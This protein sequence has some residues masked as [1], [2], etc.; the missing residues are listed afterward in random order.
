MRKKI[1]LIP[2]LLT[3]YLSCFSQL[4]DSTIRDLKVGRVKPDTSYIYWLPYKHGKKYL[5]IQ[6]RETIG[7][8]Q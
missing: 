3:F 2:I 7:N 5:L 4:P 1:F 8:R 6:G